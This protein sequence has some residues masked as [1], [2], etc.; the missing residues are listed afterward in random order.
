MLTAL[1]KLKVVKVMQVVDYY[2]GQSFRLLA[3]AGGVV[4]GVT[5]MNLATMSQQQIESRAGSMDV[6][7]LFVLSNHLRYD[8]KE[9]IQHLQDK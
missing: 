2:S 4:K 6:L 5:G 3:L 9:T 7:G 8:S 1:Q